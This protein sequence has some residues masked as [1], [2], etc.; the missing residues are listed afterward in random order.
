MCAIISLCSIY[1]GQFVSL[2]I[3]LPLLA[4]TLAVMDGVSVAYFEENEKNRTIKTYD[5]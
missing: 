5:Q 3:T 2:V 1:L 4:Y